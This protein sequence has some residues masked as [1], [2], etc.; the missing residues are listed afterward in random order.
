[1]RRLI[2]F[3]LCMLLILGTGIQSVF[4]ND[5]YGTSSKTATSD[6]GDRYINGVSYTEFFNHNNTP[7][8]RIISSGIKTSP[9]S[10]DYGKWQLNKTPVVYKVPL[11]KL[12][13][14]QVIDEFNFH[15]TTSISNAGYVHVVKLLGEDW[16]T[17]SGVAT[18]HAD[19]KYAMDN[20]SNLS[21][22]NDTDLV[23][24]EILDAKGDRTAWR[25][26]ANITSYAKQCIANNQDYM[27]VAVFGRYTSQAYGYEISDT[28]YHPAVSFVID[29]MP[30]LEL[31]SASITDGQQNVAPCS[32]ITFNYNNPIDS[33]ATTVYLNGKQAEF[34]CDSTEIVIDS[35][36]DNYSG[37]RLSVQAG[38]IYEYQLK[39]EL[40]F[41]TGESPLV[42]SLT[43]TDIVPV[44]NGNVLEKLSFR[45]LTEFDDVN[46]NVELVDS[47]A[48]QKVD[49]EF[50]LS[51]G[52]YALKQAITLDD[53][54][55]YNLI[56]KSGSTDVYS[57]TA[58]E[59]VVLS[60]FTTNVSDNN[61]VPK[62]IGA[63]A[64]VSKYD[65]LS[66]ETV[67]DS[68]CKAV[69]KIPYDTAAD[70]EFALILASYDA[71][72]DKLEFEN[73]IVSTDIIAAS[74][75]KY[76]ATEEL[77]VSQGETVKAFVVDMSSLRVLSLAVAA[78]GSATQ[79]TE[80]GKYQQEN[81]YRV[82]DNGNG[83]N[84][85]MYYKNSAYPNRPAA[86]VVYDDYAE[87][88][89][90]INQ[91]TTDSMGVLS[92]DKIQLENSSNY[93]VGISPLYGTSESTDISF[94][95]PED[96]AALWN[97][98]AVETNTKNIADNWHYI[99]P[100]FEID[101]PYIEYVKDK[102]AFYNRY[103]TL[104][105]NASLAERTDENMNTVSS[106]IGSAALYTALEQNSDSAILS[107]LFEAVLPRIKACDENTYNE[108]ASYAD[109][110]YYDELLSFFAKLEN[111][112]A[113]SPE[114][115]V[116]AMKLALDDVKLFIILE[117]AKN[118]SHI[119]EISVMLNI[120]ENA[121]LL[122]INADMPR[123]NALTSTDSIDRELMGKELTRE[124]FVEIF[125]RELDKAEKND[126]DS[127]NG[128]ASVGKG[129]SGSSKGS[130]GSSKGSSGSVPG[131]NIAVN[132]QVPVQAMV[133]F[134]DLLGYDW[135]KDHISKLYSKNIISGKSELIYAPSHNTTREE[136]VKLICTMFNIT[137]DSYVEF[138]DVDAGAW[139]TPYIN[140]ATANGIVKGIGDGVFGV[141][142]AA[143]RQ[144]VAVIITNTLKAQGYDVSSSSQLNF[145]DESDIA[146]YATDSVAYL[147]ENAIVVG[148]ESGNFNPQALITRAEI[149]VMLSRVYDKYA[150]GVNQ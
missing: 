79:S 98:I 143:S 116:S 49:A 35:Q 66:S 38:D 149:A 36:L 84:I 54:K 118:A 114:G 8:F 39:T 96:I 40:S 145:H 58:E 25:V 5:V 83:E 65:E 9:E 106:L 62:I 121:Q 127:D 37:Y 78:N 60:S 108:W 34:H 71:M 95:L 85:G 22:A 19:V 129:S 109:T 2:S 32:S 13:S 86:V 140:G 131:T 14:S 87:K 4:A 104:R 44:V 99:S 91:F 61:F 148:D 43:A 103:I 139:Y 80:P 7:V 130:S 57:N 142:K 20:Y 56:I 101:S 102:A 144:D 41:S 18:S 16:E 128:N 42:H 24:D 63:D 77:S 6:A 136:V 46:A 124:E 122:G 50:V 74:D 107:K 31:V 82:Y 110:Q 11:P 147:C 138:K 134:T 73:S 90:Y 92:L 21:K 59:N 125:N 76:I 81:G 89:T 69:V 55:T 105:G 72:A 23:R 27:Y 150:G 113:D 45:L 115:I 119:S 64:D 111:W 47:A 28:K 15:Y 123:Y 48:N 53:N 30:E 26:T 117:K 94:F 3:V 29:G 10:G 12:L 68:A 112:S 141:G 93:K 17:K 75:G 146:G 135:A 137:S 100:L 70:G 88:I 120:A 1:M 97:M 67:V 52:N 33:A 126:K 132:V 51:D 133:P